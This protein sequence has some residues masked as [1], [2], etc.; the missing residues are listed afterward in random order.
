M[1]PELKL[2]LE[3]QPVPAVHP[4]AKA[5]VKGGM[6]QDLIR[7][8]KRKDARNKKMKDQ[9]DAAVVSAAKSK[10]KSKAAV[11]NLSDKVRDSNNKVREVKASAKK[12]VPRVKGEAKQKV[13]AAMDAA[14]ADCEE[15]VGRVRRR[16]PGS[17]GRS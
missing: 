8:N 7:S 3:Q 4:R 1:V 12:E 9:R 15:G 10:A 5:V 11:K 17:H 6:I 16:S 14:M 2:E 13:H